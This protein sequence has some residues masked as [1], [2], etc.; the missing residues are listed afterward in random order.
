MFRKICVIGLGSLGSYLC[1]YLSELDQVEHLVL[2]DRDI[3]DINNCRKSAIVKYQVGMRKVDAV[4]QMIYNNVKITK[5]HQEYIEG[6]TTLP[7]SDLVIDCRDEFCKRKKEIDIRM[8]ISENHLVLDCTKNR[9]CKRRE[10]RYIFEIPKEQI[11]VAGFF[12]ARIIGSK[13]ISKM[14][15]NKIIHT[16]DLK[17]LVPLGSEEIQLILDNREDIIY[18]YYKGSEKLLQVEENLLPIFNSNKTNDIEVFIGEEH[19]VKQFLDLQKM[20]YYAV[21]PK[22]TLRQPSDIIPVLIKLTENLK[23][24]NFIVKCNLKGYK[25]HVYLIQESGSA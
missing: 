16:I 24:I 18:D 10:G 4:G 1:K 6:L 22:D 17:T 13:E 20:P 19:P 14:L 8:F 12:A 23:D 7:K 11:S 9:E 2:V 21:V 3:V 15:K 25:K 5:I